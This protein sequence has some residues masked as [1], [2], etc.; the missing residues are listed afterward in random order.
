M[1]QLYLFSFLAG[2]LAVNG[3]PH[4]VRGVTGR[5]H[6][7]PFAKKSSA[8]INVA[9]GWLNLVLA[10]IA[11]HFG[12]VRA[13]EYR[14]FTLFAVAALIMGLLNAHFFSQKTSK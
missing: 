12:H 7:T 8:E 5:K 11:L 6:Q 9:W 4:F 3:V 2:L 1:W 10:V 14:A 13:H